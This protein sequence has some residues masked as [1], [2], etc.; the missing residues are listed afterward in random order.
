MNDT[1]TTREAWLHGA[2][3]MLRPKFEEIGL[4]VPEKLHL[5]VGFG[6]GA[7]KESATILGQAFART[8]SVDQVNHIFIS[9][10][11]GDTTGVLA[12]LLHEL[13]HAADDLQSGHKGRFAE[14]AVRLGL[15]GRMTATQP[16]IELAAEL[17]TMAEVLGEYPHGRLETSMITSPAEV[18]VGPEGNPVPRPYSGP[19]RQTNRSIKMVAPD[20]GY[21]VRTTRMWLETGVPLCPHGVAMMEAQ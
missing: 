20:C 1:K 17:M 21:T 16:G 15:E 14:S 11:I 18:P 19:A 10:E 9:P 5:S 12:T 13:I 3:E 6:F 7:R 2:V 4:P 8:V